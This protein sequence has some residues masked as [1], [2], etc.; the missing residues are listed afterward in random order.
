M[1]AR[2]RI[3]LDRGTISSI[4]HTVV[5]PSSLGCGGILHT[6]DCNFPAIRISIRHAF[7]LAVVF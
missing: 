1:R 5:F 6:S 7:E 4:I 3:G 2:D